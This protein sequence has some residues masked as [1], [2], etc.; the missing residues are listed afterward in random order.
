MIYNGL[1][2]FAFLPHHELNKINWRALFNLLSCHP[3][4]LKTKID[5]VN[6]S[7]FYMNELGPRVLEFI[8]S[9]DGK[10]Y[11]A[12]GEKT[13]KFSETLPS[14]KRENL[15][16][17][18]VYASY[19][20]LWFKVSVWRMDER[21]HS[22]YHEDHLYLGTVD[23]EGRIVPIDREFVPLKD[24]HSESAILEA[25]AKVENL[26]RQISEIEKETSLSTFERIW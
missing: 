10:A 4:S 1:A 8:R 15:N 26:K 3:M 16:T 19:N 2:M 22:V 14:F 20:S 6:L 13:K 11:K 5:S 24:D 23:N 12:N 18:H 7:A 21:G 25:R 9:F 17:A